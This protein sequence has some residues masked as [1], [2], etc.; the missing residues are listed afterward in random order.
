MKT[1]G[2]TEYCL[3]CTKPD[4]RTKERNPID[5]ATMNSSQ[6]EKTN[7]ANR[8][9]PTAGESQTDEKYF[10]RRLGVDSTNYD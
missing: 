7:L 4:E 3:D 9:S 5:A 10:D 8:T 6:I 2:N 1:H